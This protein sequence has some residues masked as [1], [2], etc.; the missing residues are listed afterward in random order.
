MIFIFIFLVEMQ[1]TEQINLTQWRTEHTLEIL[2][3]S[4]PHNVRKIL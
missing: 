2:R 3:S 1:K 4:D